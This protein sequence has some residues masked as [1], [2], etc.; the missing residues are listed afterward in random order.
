MAKQINVF[1]ENR[2]GKLEQITGVLADAA[3]NILALK[4]TSD[5]QYGIFQ[6]LMDDPERGFRALQQA[7]MTAS[8]TDVVAVEVQNTP[9]SLHS[10]LKVLREANVNIED[11]YGFVVDTE[12]RAIIVLDVTDR[13][14]AK[15]VLEEQGYRI[16]G[17][18][19]L[20]SL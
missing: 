6:L 18:S 2:P 14:T 19:E 3:V 9:G 12:K 16:I 20:Y 10:V 17:S 13:A 5:E 4:I 8:L 7:G 1:L 11:C 15:R